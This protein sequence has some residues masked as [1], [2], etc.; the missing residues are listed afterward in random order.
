M[1]FKIIDNFESLRYE[2]IQYLYNNIFYIHTF[3]LNIH[4][5]LSL[6]NFIGSYFEWIEII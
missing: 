1:P 2:F 3:L 5:M 6:S 4:N